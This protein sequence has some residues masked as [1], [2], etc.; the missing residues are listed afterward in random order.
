M[1]QAKNKRIQMAFD[2]D[3]SLKRQIKI[4]A[5]MQDKSISDWIKQA[6]EIQISKQIKK[7][8]VISD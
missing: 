2:V 5:A 1:K 4:S 6:I 7:G 8:E 3:D